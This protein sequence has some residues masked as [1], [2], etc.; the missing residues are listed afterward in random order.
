[1]EY[2]WLS[3]VPPVLAIAMA[4]ITRK[5][6]ISLFSG[7]LSGALIV[8]NG[9]ISKSFQEVASILWKN[10]EIKNFSS[11]QNFQNSW[12]LFILLFCF[13][14]GAIMHLVDRAG[15]AKAYGQ[16]AL[17]HIATRAQ[18]SLST[19]FLGMII[20]FDDYFNCLTVGA[21]MRSVTDKFKISRAKLAYIIDSTTAPVCILAPISS[22]VIY[23]VSQF[24]QA[25]LGESSFT[26]FLYTILFNFYAWLSILM[27]FFVC[28]FDI[29]IGAMKYHEENVLS[30]RENDSQQPSNSIYD[31]LL[32]IAVLIV[33]II[34]GMLY[35]GNAVI[36]GGENG[37][38]QAMQSMNAGKAM[39]W[40]G[41]VSLVF[42]IVY[43][44]I[45][46]TFSIFEIAMIIWQSI[47]SMFPILFTLILSWSIGTIISEKLYTGKYLAQF[48]TGDTIKYILP[49]LI[50]ILACI[51]AFATGSSWGTFAIM[52]PIVVT[53]TQEMEN[54]FLIPTLAASLAGAIYGDHCSPISDTTILS[55]IGA[56]CRHMDHVVTQAPYSTLVAVICCVSFLLSGLTISWGILASAALGMGVGIFLLCAVVYS[57]HKAKD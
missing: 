38:I 48:L 23:V 18:A 56:E 20:F 46:R 7:V 57:H 8:H 49:M 37:L 35:T 2:G 55:S 40:G 13:I 36:V 21:V 34:A 17:N 10:S 12:H 33:S 28:V 6:I 30:P 14:L 53:M 54:N 15:G 52:I 47:K 16:W 4:F 43:F 51:T 26:I 9:S 11:W 42:S 44:A 3:L 24:N 22:W 50:F 31:L 39:F 1:M 27:V 25:G 41:V 19:M 29:N 32:P 45:R 5:I